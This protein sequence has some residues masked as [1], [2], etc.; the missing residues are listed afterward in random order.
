MT[1]TA[2]MLDECCTAPDG[3]VLSCSRCPR[4]EPVE[5]GPLDPLG[6]RKRMCGPVGAHAARRAVEVLDRE[7]SS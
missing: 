3:S 7:V 4:R 6:R 5:A 1:K 2:R